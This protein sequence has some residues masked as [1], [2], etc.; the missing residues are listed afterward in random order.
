MC[1]SLTLPKESIAQ[2][3]QL[4][5]ENFQCFDDWMARYEYLIE[6]GR[7]LPTFPDTL[8][9]DTNR[10]RGCQANL[11][12]VPEQRGGRIFF[13]AASDSAI[14]AGLAALLLKVY[15][16]RTPD[17]ILTTPPDFVRETGLERHIS[18]H[19]ANGL[20]HMLARIQAAALAAAGAN[21]HKVGQ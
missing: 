20:W 5:V 4:I 14:V 1:D 17:D 9:T 3:Q 6:L 2:T 16:G 7:S 18:P 19:R 21:N 11:W 10:L 15:S 13:L 8:R 12:I